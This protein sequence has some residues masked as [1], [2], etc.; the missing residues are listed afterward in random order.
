METLRRDAAAE[1]GPRMQEHV[2]STTVRAGVAV[3]LHPPPSILHIV[4]P[5]LMLPMNRAAMST[6][7]G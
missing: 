1:S 6:F 3:C 4:S 7:A 5:C 2:L